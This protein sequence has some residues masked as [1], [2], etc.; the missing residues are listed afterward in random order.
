[1][2][3]YK[4]FWIFVLLLCVLFPVFFVIQHRGIEQMGYQG[5]EFLKEYLGSETG[6][7]SAAQH[8]FL[9]L[10]MELFLLL[11]ILPRVNEQCLVRMT[12]V[13]HWKRTWLAMF[14]STL[15]FCLI[16]CIV[17]FIMTVICV[18]DERLWAYGFVFVSILNFVRLLGVYMIFNGVFIFL[19]C[20]CYKEEVA[21]AV[22]V[23]FFCFLFYVVFGRWKINVFNLAEDMAVYDAY[24]SSEGLGV[25]D[26]MLATVKHLLA[27]ALLYLGS[28]TLFEKK[29]ILYDEKK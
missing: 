2:S 8:G 12:R 13:K 20:I 10:A 19:Y 7:N 22:C 25:M 21:A 14:V 27:I 6:Y 4:S 3:R 17:Q 1:M 23:L 18:P 5:M 24:Y 15:A 26:Y 29:D 16:F 11:Q 28:L 9:Y